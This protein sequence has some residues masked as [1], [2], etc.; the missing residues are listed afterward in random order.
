MVLLF[1]LLIG[2]PP[3]YILTLSIRWARERAEAQGAIF[4][5]QTQ[6]KMAEQCRGEHYGLTFANPELMFQI[7]TEVKDMVL[8]L[9]GSMV[10]MAN[11]DWRQRMR[12]RA[13]AG[14]HGVARRAEVGAKALM[15]AAFFSQFP[16]GTAMCQNVVINGIPIRERC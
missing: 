7:I 1:C 14:Y 2:L 12:W 4:H 3:A 9:E 13:A 8:A 10:L 11:V 5:L 15:D 6:A 16:S